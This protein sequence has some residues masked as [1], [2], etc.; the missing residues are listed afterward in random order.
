M[1]GGLCNQ[2]SRFGLFGNETIKRLGP[3]S[4]YGAGRACTGDDALAC[5][6]VGLRDGWRRSGY[7]GG[8]YIYTDL[9]L[10]FLDDALVYIAR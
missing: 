8:T 9:L 4:E 3:V 7:S 10:V 6:G 2:L 5:N 1:V